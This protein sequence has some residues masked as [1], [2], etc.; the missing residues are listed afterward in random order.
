MASSRDVRP[1]CLVREANRFAFVMAAVLVF[2]ATQPVW[3]Q[4]PETPAVRGKRNF[5]IRTISGETRQTSSLTIQD[6]A[7]QKISDPSGDPAVDASS[8]PL[9]DISRITLLAPPTDTK[10][11]GEI[12]VYLRH[13]GFL[14]GSEASVSD[15]ELHLKTAWAESLDFTIDLVRAVIFDSKATTE[16]ARLI[17]NP[18]ADYDRIVVIV[19]DKLEVLEGLVV[20]IDAETVKFEVDGMEKSLPRDRVA[21]VA[22]AQ[23]RA[24]DDPALLKLK[25]AD[26]QLVAGE[27]ISIAGEEIKLKVAAD[28]E[29]VVPL[30]QLRELSYR[31]SQLRYLSDLTPSTVF[32]QPLVTL[33]RPWQVDRSVSGKPLTISGQVYEKGLG[34]HAVCRLTYTIEPGFDVFVA[35]IGLDAVAEGKGNC[36]FV[37]LGD[38]QQLL[39]ETIKGKE[40]PRTIRVPLRG[41]RELTI[42]VEAGAD[43]DLA[44]H[45][46]WCDARLLKVKTP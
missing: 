5:Q 37:V 31:S 26:D 28:A 30:T 1:E 43:L 14:K 3:S 8:I 27:S 44:D 9:D 12:L 13:Q 16:V 46:N 22:I 19:D 6:N 41:V 15:D 10:S 29:V 21:A 34:V 39:S 7:V 2:C 32:E 20:N 40:G 45:A 23:A 24:D 17:K 25:L 35:D 18:S 4:V 42:A 38:G 33:K 11:T 36:I